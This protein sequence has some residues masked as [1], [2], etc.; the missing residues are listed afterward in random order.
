ML[1]STSKK[2][3]SAVKVAEPHKAAVVGDTG[4]RPVQGYF[5]SI[6]QYLD[7]INDYRCSSI[8][9]F[10]CKHWWITVI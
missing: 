8:R 2:V 9:T 10:I 5:R 1:R 7:Q 4:R 3:T 6:Y